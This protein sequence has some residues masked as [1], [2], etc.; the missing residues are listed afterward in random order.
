MDGCKFHVAPLETMV[1]T[2]VCLFLQENQIIPGFLGL[3]EMDF[4][5]PHGALAGLELAKPS[6][7]RE[8][9]GFWLFDPSNF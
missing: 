1:E 7:W 9:T 6:A 2:I 5:H 4:V 3:C 8:K